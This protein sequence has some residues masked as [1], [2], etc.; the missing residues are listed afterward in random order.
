MGSEYSTLAQN[1]TSFDE[2]DM[3]PRTLSLRRID[4]GSDIE[5]A[6]IAHNARYHQSCKLKYITAKLNRVMKDKIKADEV[7]QKTY[8]PETKRR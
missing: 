1:L 6:M 4:H 3:L 2:I 8:E 5:A 7:C